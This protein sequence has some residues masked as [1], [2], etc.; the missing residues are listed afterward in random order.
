MKIRDVELT[1]EQREKLRL[2]L[3]IEPNACEEKYI[4]VAY[5]ELPKQIQPWFKLCGLS[6]PERLRLGD[7]VTTTKAV[8]KPDKNPEISVELHRA[9]FTIAVCE[10]GILEWGNYIN[11]STGDEVP[12]TKKGKIDVLAAPLL[13][14]LSARILSL[15]RLADEEVLGLKS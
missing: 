12:F 7:K 13:N 4:P 3:P 1:E 2:F 8:A 14:E 5:R 9:E 10:N 6:G 15:G 11:P